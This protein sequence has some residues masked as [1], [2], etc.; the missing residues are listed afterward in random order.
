MTMNEDVTDFARQ[1]YDKLYDA[2]IRVEI[3]DRVESIGKKVREASI[4]RFN[5]M[6]TIGNQEKEDGKIAVKARDEKELKNYSV[7]EF[8]AKVVEELRERK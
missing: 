6:V 3:D 5:Y 7:D 1:V 2:G 8:V 4:D